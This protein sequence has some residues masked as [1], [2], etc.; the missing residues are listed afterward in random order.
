M[1]CNRRL[2]LWVCAMPFLLP[3]ALTCCLSPAEQ[4]ERLYSS[5]TTVS[6]EVLGCAHVMFGPHDS[7]W[8]TQAVIWWG[9]AC[10]GWNI[11]FATR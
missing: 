11:M 2:C 8:A 4:P 7:T 5:K 3:L 10:Q 6:G 1:C 9:L